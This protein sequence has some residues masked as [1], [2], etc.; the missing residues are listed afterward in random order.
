MTYMSIKKKIVLYPQFKGLNLTDN[1]QEFVILYCQPGK[2]TTATQAY[3]DAFKS[4]NRPSASR[5]AS[6]LLKNTDIKLAIEIQTL[7]RLRKETKEFLNKKRE[8]K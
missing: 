7:K 3:V 2:H 8:G 1:Q 4:K 5:S 6:K